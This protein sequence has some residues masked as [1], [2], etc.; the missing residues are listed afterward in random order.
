MR[1]QPDFKEQAKLQPQLKKSIGTLTITRVRDQT[2]PDSCTERELHT[3]TCGHSGQ[4]AAR[5]HTASS[6]ILA[7]QRAEF[8]YKQANQLGGVRRGDQHVK[9]AIQL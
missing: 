4:T 7:H 9:Q 1:G 3:H 8:K 5:A 2:M 6:P